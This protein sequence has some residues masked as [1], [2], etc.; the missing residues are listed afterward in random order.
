VITETVP[1]GHVPVSMR[2]DFERPA[3]SFTVACPI[4][5]L[6][7]NLGLRQCLQIGNC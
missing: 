6:P 7:L 2:L 5:V 1:L 3:I 4:N